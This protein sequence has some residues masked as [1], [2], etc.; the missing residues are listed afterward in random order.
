MSL[1]EPARF[2][3]RLVPM[4]RFFRT[5]LFLV[6]I[7]IAC[8][9]TS[10]VSQ[11]LPSTAAADPSPPD[12]PLS[13]TSQPPSTKLVATLSIPPI[14]QPPDGT[15]TIAPTGSQGC[16]YRWAYQDL[17]DLSNEFQSA[18]QG[19]Q[20]GATGYAIAF[21]EDCVHD[22][23]SATFVPMETDFNITL[24]VDDTT[25]EAE[26][27]DWIVRV[28]QV[29]ANIPPE[30]ITGPRPGRVSLLFES[31]AER[32]GISFYIDQYQA[33]PV[34]LDSSELFRTLQQSQ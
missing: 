32:T 13:I 28:M 10:A 2:K 1:Q 5:P 23:G 30:K 3:I 26:L 27:G 24:P 11:P 7:L 6:L 20:P 18:L 29:I 9:P 25:N 31:G 22:D 14:E 33:L 15:G 34:N 4:V 17:P 19:L 8:S 12:I 16:A 21:G